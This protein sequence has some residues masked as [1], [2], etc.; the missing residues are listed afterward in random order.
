[1]AWLQLDSLDATEEITE[2]EENTE[3][4]STLPAWTL[5]FKIKLGDVTFEDMLDIPIRRVYYL[6][7][8]CVCWR[9]SDSV[10]R[11]LK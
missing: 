6:I 5:Q 7:G 3:V 4:S 8:V 11:Q 10:V 1:M 9:S 2:D